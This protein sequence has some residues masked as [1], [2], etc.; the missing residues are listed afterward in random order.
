MNL[1]TR[2]S[3][4]KVS[5]PEKNPDNVCIAVKPPQIEDVEQTHST[6]S[7]SKSPLFDF[8]QHHLTNEMYNCACKRA[9]QQYS[10]KMV[11]LGI[12]ILF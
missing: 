10:L 1:I 6:W 5:G 4:S 9:M 3:L 2:K 12:V 11:W 8:Y 7:G